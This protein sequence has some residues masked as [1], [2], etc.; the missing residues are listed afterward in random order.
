MSTGFKWREP[1]RA[2]AGTNLDARV[3]DIVRRE[4]SSN[5]VRQYLTP[6]TIPIAT[7]D[8]MAVNLAY[9]GTADYSITWTSFA[10]VDS[11][12]LRLVL[13]ACSG[14]PIRVRFGA[15]M[16]KGTTHV[17]LSLAYD[18]TEVTGNIGLAQARSTV[19]ETHCSIPWTIEAPTPGDHVLTLQALVD[20]GTGTVYSNAVPITIE[21][22]EV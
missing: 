11:A 20:A 21:A 14:R 18:G 19:A 6:N 7:V 8:R 5:G 22:E 12:N 16:A 9:V 2:P 4:V 15:S 17:R 3:A 10:D 13:P 1:L